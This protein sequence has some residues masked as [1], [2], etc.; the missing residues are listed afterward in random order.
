MAGLSSQGLG[1]GL[2]DF[3]IAVL[4]GTDVGRHAHV[5]ANYGVGEI[6][7]GDTAAHFIQH[8]VS[9][10]ASYAITDDWN[11]YVEAFWFSRQDSTGPS[12]TSIDAGAI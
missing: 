11:P 6:G 5:D 4:T 3:T 1:S 12:V 9:V 2:A 10:S 8:L 7:S